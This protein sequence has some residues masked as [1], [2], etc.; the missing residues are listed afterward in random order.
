MKYSLIKLT[1]LLNKNQIIF[2]F[3][4]LFRFKID[5]FSENLIKSQNCFEY[6]KLN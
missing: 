5:S 1:L 3:L 2:N 4:N 6:L